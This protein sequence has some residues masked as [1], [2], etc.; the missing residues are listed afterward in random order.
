MTEPTW[1]WDT[2]AR[3][4][5]AEL[6]DE[7]VSP[8]CVAAVLDQLETLRLVGASCPTGFAVDVDDGAVR[9]T[10]IRVCL[11]WKLPGRGLLRVYT[12]RVVKQAGF[13][14]FA[15]E[16]DGFNQAVP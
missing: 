11:S 16:S 10:W 9:R 4:I 2:A 12:V 15:V 5:E 13:V 7:K 3:K 14:P 8:N 6:Y 1:T